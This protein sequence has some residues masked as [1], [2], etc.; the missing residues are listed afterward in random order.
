MQIAE[1]ELCANWLREDINVNEVY[2][3]KDE[4]KKYLIDISEQK[5]PEKLGS[6]NAFIAPKTDPEKKMKLPYLMF[7]YQYIQEQD[8]SGKKNPIIVRS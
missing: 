1:Y 7:R 6:P 8:L 5:N 2:E 4:K 3:K